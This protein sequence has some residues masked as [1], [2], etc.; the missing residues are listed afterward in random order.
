MLQ[1]HNVVQR[2]INVVCLLGSCLDSKIMVFIL[3]Q[4]DQIYIQIF[5][6]IS[7]ATQQSQDSQHLYLPKTG[8]T[9][10]NGGVEVRTFE[11]LFYEVT[12]QLFNA[13][14]SL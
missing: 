10:I 9:C 7:M 8:Q 4:Y 14:L 11:T 12:F 13:S 2:C 5:S 3:Y 1:N 6:L